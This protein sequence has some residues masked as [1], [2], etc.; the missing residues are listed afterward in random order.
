MKHILIIILFFS[1]NFNVISQIHTLKTK[2]GKQ[3]NLFEDGTWKYLDE[4]INKKDNLK[5]FDCNQY[6]VTKEDKV[7]G[8]VYK[9][10]KEVIKIRDGKENNYLEINFLHIINENKIIGMYIKLKG[11]TYCINNNSKLNIL[12]KDGTRLELLSENDFNCKGEF[13]IYFGDYYLSNQNLLELINKDIDVIRVW[14]E[15]GYLEKK[16]TIKNSNI[17]RNI[18]KCM[19]KDFD[20][21]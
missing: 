11:N 8:D 19:S 12:F 13:T 15:D 18:L 17:F 14:A 2:D 10:I 3:V 20:F 4:P 1:F 9:E 7:T 16:F 21:K 6:I 5:D